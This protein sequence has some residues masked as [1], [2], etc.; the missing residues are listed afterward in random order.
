LLHFAPTPSEITVLM[1]HYCETLGK[2][3]KA[4]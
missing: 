2:V 3:D 1:A 4:A